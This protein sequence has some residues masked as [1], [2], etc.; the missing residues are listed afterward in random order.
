MC[1]AMYGEQSRYWAGA[2]IGRG[3]QLADYGVYVVRVIGNRTRL[4][5][6]GQAAGT[7]AAKAHCD[8]SI[9]PIGKEV[10]KLLAQHRDPTYRSPPG[11]GRAPD[12]LDLR[13]SRNFVSDWDCDMTDIAD[14]R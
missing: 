11:R 1:A 9:T 5:R 12:G 7:V 4:E 10:Q 6:L 14:Q 3:T 2:T 13:G 8:C